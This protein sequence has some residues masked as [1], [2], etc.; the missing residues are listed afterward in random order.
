MTDRSLCPPSSSAWKHW[1][2]SF[3]IAA[4]RATCSG[5]F[6]DDALILQI[7]KT[8]LIGSPGNNLLGGQD[9]ILDETAD[10][11]IGYTEFG[12]GLGH[13]QPFAVLLGGPIAVNSVHSTQRADAVGGPGL[14][15]SR[16][17]SHSVQRRGGVR[18]RPSTRHAPH[19]GKRFFGR[20]AALF[21]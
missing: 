5:G 19:N 13:R 1:D 4:T 9:A 2:L 6:G 17:H 12:R 14:A 16:G 11:M 21:T 10:A 15:L 20:T 8:N 3:G 7:A 18:I